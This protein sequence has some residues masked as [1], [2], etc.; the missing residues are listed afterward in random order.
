VYTRGA[1]IFRYFA[2][3]TNSWAIRVPGDAWISRYATYLR[4]RESIGLLKGGEMT[5]VKFCVA[6]DVS[7]VGNVRFGCARIL[8]NSAIAEY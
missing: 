2:V 7:G 4:H 8:Q 3:A 5:E 6:Q 1:V